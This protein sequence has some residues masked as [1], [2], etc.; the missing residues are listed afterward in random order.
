M[1]ARR[2]LANHVVVEHLGR[3]SPHALVPGREQEIVVQQ[4]DAK[5]EI[6]IDGKLHWSE[7]GQ[8]RGTVSVMPAVGSTIAIR[9]IRVE[10]EIVPGIT[11]DVPW[12]LYSSR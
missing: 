9:E 4:N 10:G 3:T 12:F 7:R 2:G 5:I 1:L 11:V 8:L 6:L